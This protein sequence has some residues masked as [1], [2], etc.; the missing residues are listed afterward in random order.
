MIN[1][2]EADIPKQRKLFLKSEIA[3][4]IFSRDKDL[5]IRSKINISMSIGII[6]K[7]FKKVWED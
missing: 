3:L 1:T 5:L 4:L 6:P 7:L 2:C